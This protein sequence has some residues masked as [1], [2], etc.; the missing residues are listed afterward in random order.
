MTPLRSSLDD[1]ENSSLDGDAFTSSTISQVRVIT[2]DLDNTLWKTDPVIAAA[3]NA[4]NDYLTNRIGQTPKRV[5]QV[6]KELYASNP[7]IYNPLLEPEDNKTQSTAEYDGSTRSIGSPVYLTKLRIDSIKE[8]LSPHHATVDDLDKIAKDAFHVWDKARHAAIPMHYADS[9]LETLSTLRQIRTSEGKSVV[10]GAITDGNSDPRKVKDL[11]DY[12][13][14]VINAESVGVSKPNKKIYL[15][16]IIE[17]SRYPVVQKLLPPSEVE[18]TLDNDDDDYLAFVG[19]WWVHVGDDFMKD[20][21]PAKELQMRNIWTVEL[22]PK[23]TEPL[24]SDDVPSKKSSR[25]QV[26]DLMKEISSQSVVEMTIGT[27]DFLIDSFQSEFVDCK[28]DSFSNVASIITSWHTMGLAAL[29]YDEGG[30]DEKMIDYT[31]EE[32]TGLLTEKDSEKIGLGSSGNDITGQII[33]P[34]SDGAEKNAVSEN[35]VSKKFC[36]NCGTS[37][38]YVAKFCFSCGEKQPEM[39]EYLERPTSKNS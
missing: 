15:R 31:S 5:E 18:M 19:P 35:K 1:D 30:Q 38:P 20:V 32:N 34:T 10:I 9:M 3:N 33:S 21:V 23:S 4:L 25:R 27:T 7:H 39:T 13:D 12:F 2:F 36:M 22:L 11:Q 6:M 26:A 37:I 17:A 24:D 28:V 8:L 29:H 16:A 14:F